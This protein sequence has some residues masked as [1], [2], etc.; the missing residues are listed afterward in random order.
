VLTA[1]PDGQHRRQPGRWEPV[2][3]PL[4]DRRRDDRVAVERQVRTVLLERARR[5]YQHLPFGRLHVRPARVDQAR[6][7]GHLTR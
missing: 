7:D 2:V 1:R 6:H 5:D 3:D 4:G